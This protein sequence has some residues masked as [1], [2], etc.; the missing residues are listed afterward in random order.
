M[1]SSLIHNPGDHTVIAKFQHPSIYL[2]TWAIREISQDDS[3]RKRFIDVLYKQNGTLLFSLALNVELARTAGNSYDDVMKTLKEV[4]TKWF[5]IDVNAVR[6]IEKEEKAVDGKTED[7][8]PVFFDEA[9]MRSYYPYVSDEEPTL[10]KL[11]ELLKDQKNIY[12]SIHSSVGV[13]AQKIIN[14]RK[15]FK[16]QHPLFNQEA[17]LEKTFNPQQPTKY[18]YNGL[19]RYCFESSKN[20]GVND[21]H[22]LYHAAVPIAYADFVILEKSWHD[23]AKSRLKQVPQIDE[24]IFFSVDVFLAHIEKDFEIIKECQNSFLKAGHGGGNS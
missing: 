20:I 6:V 4:G 17:F 3:K 16:N 23:I 11:E 19:M 8:Q 10:G 14:A 24:R 7:G 5:P 12:D 9:F 18:T 15:Y 22:D 21:I 1:I 13:L 2:D